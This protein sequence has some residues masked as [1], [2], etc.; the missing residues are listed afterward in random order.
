MKSFELGAGWADQTHNL[1]LDVLSMTGVVGLVAWI[2]VWGSV[3]YMLARAWRQGKI[4]GPV[5]AVMLGFPSGLLASKSVLFDHITSFIATGII[6]ALVISL[7]RG[8][9]ELAG[10]VVVE[11]PLSEQE[12][13]RNR[14]ERRLAERR[15]KK[16]RSPEE[17]VTPVV[18]PGLSPVF[19]MVLY[20]A[21]LVILV[22]TTVLPTLASARLV[23]ADMAAHGTQPRLAYASAKSAFE[24]ISIY[25]YDVV[26]QLTD[27]FTGVLDPFLK[28]PE[29]KKALELLRSEGHVAMRE[30]R[31]DSRLWARFGNFLTRYGAASGD[32]AILNEAREVLSHSVDLAPERAD[33]RVML[34]R[35]HVYTG[36]VAAATE[37]LTKATSL[38][39]GVGH[40]WFMASALWLELGKFPEAVPYLVSAR[41]ARAPWK[42]PS[43]QI[44]NIYAQ[45]LAMKGEKEL[46]QKLVPEIEAL[47]RGGEN[48][49]LDAAKAYERMEL[50]EERDTILWVAMRDPQLAPKLRPVVN[51]KLKRIEQ[52]FPPASAAPPPPRR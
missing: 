25:R 6:F 49:L 32:K 14:K 35:V 29:G 46:M 5:F 26:Y 48:M 10:P 34:A 27:T 20:A 1:L 33:F 50:M 31:M 18:L 21:A 38:D 47:T 36:D 52:A 13:E 22:L 43:A 9:P 45:A 37:E 19:P 15:E 4:H 12:L 2:G 44:A 3:Y 42:A 30:H 11:A 17:Q 39:P 28:D 16:K 40:V 24:T 41:K 51:G 23:D 7:S 8:I